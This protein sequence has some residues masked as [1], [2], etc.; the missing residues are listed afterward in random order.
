MSLSKLFFMLTISLLLFSLSVHA[1]LYKWIDEEGQTHYGERPPNRQEAQ[2]I[3][4]P[5]P[6]ASS[7]GDSSERIQAL[8]SKI[9]DKA[10]DNEKKSE[11]IK[12]QKSENELQHKY[13]DQ[14][15]QRLRIRQE[16]PRIR[17]QRD[18]GSIIFLDEKT[19][20]KQKLE[21]EQK[22]A[23]DCS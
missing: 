4:P 21:L 10:A 23:K 8:R 16:N 5:P 19:T 17:T 7:A 6:R 15:R 12:K 11:E 9:L 14:L 20:L 13:C 22:I 2:S 1:K 3:A 18:D